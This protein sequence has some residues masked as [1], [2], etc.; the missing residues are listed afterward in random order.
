MM[1]MASTTANAFQ[2]DVKAV[3]DA[4]MNEHLAKPLEVD[5][6]LKL[7]RIILGKEDSGG[8]IMLKILVA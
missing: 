3:L 8:F 2:D 1:K 7:L 5:V 4:G 6:L